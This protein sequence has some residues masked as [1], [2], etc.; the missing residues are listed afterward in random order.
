M[1]VGPKRRLSAKELMLSNY[2]ANHEYSFEGLML[3][4]QYFGHMMQKANS[5]EKTI[6]LGKL[7]AEGG[8]ETGW[9][10]WMASLTQWT[11]IWENWEIVEERGAWHTAVQGVARSQIWLSNWT[12]TH[13]LIYIYTLVYILFII[14]EYPVRC[15]CVCV[16]VYIYIYIYIHMY[17]H[18]NFRIV[19]EVM[20]VLKLAS[21]LLVFIYV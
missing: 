7:K 6:M 15:V 4:L 20:P 18:E 21:I 12:T 1:R 8:G 16:C 11:W 14:V 5:F 9:D 10:G 2:S 13:I 3:K 17:T 19:Y